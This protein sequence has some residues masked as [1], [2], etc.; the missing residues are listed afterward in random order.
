MKELTPEQKVAR[1]V[2]LSSIAIE[3]GMA[4]EAALNEMRTKVAA[5]IPATVQALLDGGIISAEQKK[6]AEAILSDPA[7]TI[8]LLGRVA[9]QGGT[10]SAS[11]KPLGSG[12]AAGRKAAPEVTAKQAAW[13]AFAGAILG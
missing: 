2:E 3:K 7:K 8:Q 1:H 5:H 10:K 12:T 9:A 4:A 11:V 13:D 6:A